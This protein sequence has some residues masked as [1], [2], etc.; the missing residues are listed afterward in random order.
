MTNPAGTRR[1]ARGPRT[2]LALALVALLVSACASS[3]E[4]PQDEGF[5]RSVLPETLDIVVD[6]KNFED[7]SVFFVSDTGL[8]R[9]LGTVTGRTVRTFQVSGQ[10]IR[11]ADS[12]RLEGDLVGVTERIRTES[13]TTL[14]ANTYWALGQTPSMSTVEQW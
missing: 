11:G 14:R 12:F 13:L 3:G 9:R 6:N 5:G 2:G 10:E 4:G 8:R 1:N 7:L